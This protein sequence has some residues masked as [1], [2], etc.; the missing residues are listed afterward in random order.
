MKN[1]L[2]KI[3]NNLKLKNNQKGV[4]LIA[5]VITI[6]LMLILTITINVNVDQYGEQKLKTN[7]ESDM[8]RLE[9][10]ISQYFAREKELPII[11][12]YINVVMLTG[13]KNVN[14]NNNYYVIDL[15][16]IDVKLNYGKDF[17]IIK[18]R[19]RAE[20]ISDLSDVYI[21]NEQS[22]TIYYPKGVN[23][24]GKIHYLSDN[25]YSNIDI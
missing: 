20:E 19:S 14:D 6:V 18:S 9:Q 10:A 23:Y 8:S 13:I 4:T 25:V 17:D 22:H 5:L 2:I 1:I 15:E 21:I 3:K 12:K 24:R 7:Y 16:K 11:N